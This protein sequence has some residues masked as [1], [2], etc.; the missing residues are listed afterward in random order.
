MLLSFCR[1]RWLVLSGITTVFLYLALMGP[2]VWLEQH[3]LL[4]EPVKTIAFVSYYPVRLLREKSLMVDRWVNSYA[5]L[6]INPIA[7]P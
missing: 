4:V 6:W 1:W 7:V 2:L 3:G 5:K